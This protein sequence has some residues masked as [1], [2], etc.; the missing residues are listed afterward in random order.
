LGFVQGTVGNTEDNIRKALFVEEFVSETMFPALEKIAREKG[1]E[2]LATFYGHM[3]EGEA[4]HAEALRGA[5]EIYKARN[6]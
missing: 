6:Q 1:N 3:A 2:K 4:K 5:L